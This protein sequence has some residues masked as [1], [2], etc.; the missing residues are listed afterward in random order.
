[1][2]RPSSRTTPGTDGETRSKRQRAGLVLRGGTPCPPGMLER[3][4]NAQMC[5]CTLIAQGGKRFA[6][7]KL[8]LACGSDYMSALFSGEFADSH[9]NEVRLPDLPVSS[10]A[11]ALDWLYSGECSLADPDELLPVLRAARLLQIAGL[12]DACA[13]AVRV[14]LNLDNV[15]ER[16]RSPRPHAPACACRTHQASPL[17][18]ARAWPHAPGARRDRAGRRAEPAVAPVGRH[19]SARQRLWRGLRRGRRRGRRRSRR[20]LAAAAS[21]QHSRGRARV[22][23]AG[24]AV[25]GGG[26]RGGAPLGAPPLPRRGAG[27]RR[28][29]QCGRWR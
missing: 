11:A 9:S 20:R 27:R 1:M 2:K 17:L 13:D 23:L 4:R 6:A 7:H 25:G 12:L 15:R 3:W 5:D 18:S 22:R 10:A 19:R 14:R 26:V 21:G 29:R 16:V 8:V 28:E 24:G